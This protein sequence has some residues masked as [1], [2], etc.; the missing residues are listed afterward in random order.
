MSLYDGWE[1]ILYLYFYMG[2]EKKNNIEK[3]I[4]QAWPRHHTFTYQKC[5][6]HYQKVKIRRPP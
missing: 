3:Y 1:Y 6:K 4:D 5:L 2:T